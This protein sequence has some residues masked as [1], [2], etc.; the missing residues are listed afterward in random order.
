MHEF[1]SEVYIRY[2]LGIHRVYIRYTSGIQKNT[3]EYI[4]F[5][6]YKRYALRVKNIFN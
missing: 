5:Y 2:T 1:V 6:A 4:S 3:K